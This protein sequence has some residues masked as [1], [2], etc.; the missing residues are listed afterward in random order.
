MFTQKTC[1]LLALAGM[2]GASAASAWQINWGQYESVNFAQQ[3]NGSYAATFA[4]VDGS[5]IDLTVSLTLNGS[6]TVSASHGW[7]N[8]GA[9]QSGYATN[10]IAINTDFASLADSVTVQF[11]FSQEV[12]ELSYTLYDIG[13]DNPSSNPQPYQDA[14]SGLGGTDG[15]GNETLPIVAAGSAVQYQW[16]DGIQDGVYYGTGAS[17]WYQSST[18]YNMTVNYGSSNA[19]TASF[20]FGAGN[21]EGNSAA[22]PAAQTIYLSSLSFG[23]AVASNP[24]SPVPEPSTVALLLGVAALGGVLTLRGFRRRKA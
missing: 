19:Q 6:G 10:G 22:N 21:S 3:E 2:F 18:D 14:I 13:V 15:N 12:G 16:Q 23:E 8:W 5:G 9:A 11:S 20:T 17:A 1:L 24:G 4:D 7:V